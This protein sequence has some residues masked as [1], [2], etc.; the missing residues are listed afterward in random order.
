MQV[1]RKAA[2]DRRSAAA[3]PRTGSNTSVPL[4]CAGSDQPESSALPASRKRLG[5]SGG[6]AAEV[7]SS[8][9]AW[10]RVYAVYNGRRP[11]YQ[12][13]FLA[14]FRHLRAGMN[15]ITIY[16][17]PRC[18][19][20]RQTLQ[21]I[22]QSG[23]SRGIVLSVEQLPTP[24]QLKALLQKLGVDARGLLRKGETE[25]A[26]LGLDN[27]TLS[28]DALIAAMCSNPR[29]IER[30][31]VVRGARAVLGRPPENVLGLLS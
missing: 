5:D 10:S 31:V 20:S 15:D 11:V 25:Y 8:N 2:Q 24:V 1:P 14:V 22:E 7:L 27:P 17:N 21:L 6:Y 28:D 4:R 26:Q 12:S 3:L 13:L 19:K 23:I 18:S 29:L 9:L 16:H 30:P